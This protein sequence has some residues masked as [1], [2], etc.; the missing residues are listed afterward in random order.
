MSIIIFLG[1]CKWITK[2]IKKFFYKEEKNVEHKRP[3]YKNIENDFEE[4]YWHNYPYFKLKK[5][6]ENSDQNGTISPRK[7]KVDQLKKKMGL[8][9]F[10]VIKNH[11]HH[12]LYSP[13]V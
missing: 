10:S 3:Q 11:L 9:G 2:I 8:D 5:R 12:D 4:D 13:I 1:G 7:E 6:E